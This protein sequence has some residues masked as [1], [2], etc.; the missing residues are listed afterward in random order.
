[1]SYIYYSEVSMSSAFCIYKG[2]NR[3]FQHLGHGVDV[4]GKCVRYYCVVLYLKKIFVELVSS[5]FSIL[6]DAQKSEPR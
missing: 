6:D 5:W 3:Q 2:R 4:V 1:M